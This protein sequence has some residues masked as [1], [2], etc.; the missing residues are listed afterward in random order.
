MKTGYLEG[1][2]NAKSLITLIFRLSAEKEKQSLSYTNASRIH[3]AS[4]IDLQVTYK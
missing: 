1:F 2:I 3:N 4:R